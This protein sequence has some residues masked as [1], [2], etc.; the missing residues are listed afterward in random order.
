M[1]LFV[2][3]V[4]I[5]YQ[6]FNLYGVLNHQD[7][8]FE[9]PIPSQKEQK[10]I[11]LQKLVNFNLMGKIQ[12][13]PSSVVEIPKELPKT[14]LKLQLLG[15]LLNSEVEN[16]SV[17]IQSNRKDTRRYYVGDKISKGVEI[18]EIDTHRVIVLRNGKHEAL[19]YKNT[20]VTSSPSS[21][22]NDRKAA[23][24]TLERSVEEKKEVREL[25]SLRAQYNKQQLEVKR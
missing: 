12:K 8:V 14:T 10:P 1:M 3:S 23:V 5:S 18:A 25:F 6:I 7:S 24:Q 15:I 17:L 13:I 4:S 16:S 22:P 9:S 2:M 20:T 21:I 19:S 11:S